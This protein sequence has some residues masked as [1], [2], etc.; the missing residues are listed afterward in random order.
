[1][2]LTP[3]GECS[4]H[5]AYCQV[6]RNRL[7]PMTPNPPVSLVLNELDR[8]YG[9]AES[10]KLFTRPGFS[11]MEEDHQVVKDICLSGDGE[12]SLYPE[13]PELLNALSDRAGKWGVALH[14]LSN[15]VG[16]DR[17]ELLEPFSRF[18]PGVD[19]L[20]L[21]A[22]AWSE[23]DLWEIHRRRESFH[24]YWTRTENLCRTLPVIFQ[25][26]VFKLRNEISPRVPPE[27][28]GKRIKML[29]R[30]RSS[31][32]EQMYVYTLSRPVHQEHVEG[33]IDSELIDWTK[34]LGSIDLP[35][36]V[37]GKSGELKL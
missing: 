23:R 16:L 30:A 3:G 5:C 34:R 9:E 21:K 8:L 14:I 24:A 13:L 31:K 1:M 36:R 10:G 17:E 26:C 35:I 37:F 11:E 19:S 25:T 15:G 27:H 20:W 7:D 18:R 29:A 33:L 4:Y 12:P 2:N 22:D 6:D 28:L 32:L